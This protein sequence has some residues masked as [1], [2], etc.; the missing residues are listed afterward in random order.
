MLLEEGLVY[1]LERAGAVTSVVGTDPVRLYPLALPQDCELPA[2]TYTPVSTT[3]GVLASGE[4]DLPTATVQIDAWADDE[5]SGY[6]QAK[7]L[8]AAVRSVLHGFRGLAGEVEVLS[9]V[10]SIARDLSEDSG[11]F[12]RVSQDVTIRYRE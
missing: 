9:S 1:L 8:A 12:W 11:S 2:L 4:T 6:A 5:V 3:Y 7:E 10:V